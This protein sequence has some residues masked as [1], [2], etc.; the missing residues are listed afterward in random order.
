MASTFV[1]DLAVVIALSVLF[2]TP[3]PAT[4]VFL[5]ISVAVVWLAP[6]LLPPVFLR[7]GK[8]VI[9]PEL[10]LLFA[11]LLAFMVL[12]HWGASQAVLPVFVLGFSLSRFFRAQPALL[13]K[14]RVVG[15][16][17]VTPFFFLKGGME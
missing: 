11:L 2:V 3:G 14:L 10:K 16:A 7:Y 17:F 15:F 9:E 8:R 4:W 5:G 12:A 6:K 1:T 13:H